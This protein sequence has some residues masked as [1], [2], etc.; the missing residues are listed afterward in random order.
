ME[1]TIQPSE[2][3]LDIVENG[4]KIPFNETS[5]HY[6]FDNRSSAIKNRSFVEEEIKKL[7]ESSCIEELDKPT[8][9]CNPLHVS[10]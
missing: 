10:G 2:F 9:F 4:Y 7:L 6:K 3:V 5:S 1:R 8:P